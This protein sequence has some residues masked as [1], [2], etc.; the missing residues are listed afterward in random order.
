MRRASDLCLK[1]A[2][3]EHL[4][5]ADIRS[6]IRLDGHVWAI[7]SAGPRSRPGMLTSALNGQ[8]TSFDME[9][10]YVRKACRRAPGKIISLLSTLT[11][12]GWGHRETTSL[13][14]RV[15]KQNR[16]LQSQKSA[17]V[18]FWII[19]IFMFSLGKQ[20]WNTTIPRSLMCRRGNKDVLFGKIC[21]FQRADGKIKATWTPGHEWMD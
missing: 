14:F 5:R 21:I 1:T 3:S 16:V 17:S 12:S 13:S 8:S 10:M 4:L 2:G 6:R 18:C 11:A 9:L 19:C 15:T 7:S 20:V